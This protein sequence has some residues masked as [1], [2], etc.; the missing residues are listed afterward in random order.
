MLKHER[1]DLTDWA[2]HINKL[3]NEAYTW[4]GLTRE[5]TDVISAERMQQMTEFGINMED[6]EVVKTVFLT[7]AYIHKHYS[8][9]VHHIRE[10]GAPHAP[11][12]DNEEEMLKVT[13][14]D[15]TASIIGRALL[16]GVI[17]SD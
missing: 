11:D 4:N 10:H 1:E 5:Q 3:I 17:T 12:Q 6:K 16:K 15:I 14:G 2:N 13:L 7:L 9:V 8:D